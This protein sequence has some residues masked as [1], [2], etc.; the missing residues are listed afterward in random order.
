MASAP[1]SFLGTGWHFPPTFTENGRDVWRVADEED[2]QQSLQILLATAQGERVML[3]DFG[4]DLNRFVFEEMDRSLRNSLAGFVKVALLR[5]EPR[6]AVEDVEAEPSN[7][8]E[9]LLLIHVVYRVPATNSRF[10][11]VFPFY[12]NEGAQP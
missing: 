11:L 8:T 10:N 3:E 4:C 1:S 2:I 7:E 5:Y 6:I 9:G 12:L